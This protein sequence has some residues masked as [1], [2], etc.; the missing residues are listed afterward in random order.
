MLCALSTPALA[1]APPRTGA[2]K[3]KRAL[4]TSEQAQGLSQRAQRDYER[5]QY[6]RALEQWKKAYRLDPEP[7]YLFNIAQCYRK[8]EMKAEAR[9]AYRAYL[10]LEPKDPYRADI[11]LI[12]DDYD[13]LL[14]AEQDAE[15]RAKRDR[16]DALRAR[17]PRWLYAASG[18]FAL[19]SL[20]AGGTGMGF[21]LSSRGAQVDGDLNTALDRRDASLRL[22]RVA[23]L[24]LGV[25]LLSGGAGFALDRL[26]PAEDD[27][28]PAPSTPAQALLLSPGGVAWMIR[29]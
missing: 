21:A 6:Q 19:A 11:E 27:A 4:S 23:Q 10:R 24:S 1:A 12:I 17:A 13:L 7:S 15:A 3:P 14:R 16:R 22:G 29:F 26:S 25:A 5:Q 9:D 2:A 18:S 8:L 28:A 20:A